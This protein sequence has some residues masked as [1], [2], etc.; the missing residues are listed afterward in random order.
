METLCDIEEKKMSKRC[1]RGEDKHEY[2]FTFSILVESYGV[3]LDLT[4]YDP[5]STQKILCVNNFVNRNIE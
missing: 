5:L 3:D 1:P 4:K 2:K